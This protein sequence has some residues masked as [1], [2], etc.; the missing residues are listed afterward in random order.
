MEKV[1][2][3]KCQ[4][5]TFGFVSLSREP[6]IVA[7]ALYGIIFYEQLGASL[8][9]LG[10][11][12]A[13]ARGF[14]ILNDPIIAS[15]TDNTTTRIGKRYPWI[16]GGCLFFAGSIIAFWTPP[17]LAGIEAWFGVFYLLLW[18]FASI[19]HI[20][21]SAMVPEICRDVEERQSI[22]AH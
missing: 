19:V 13:L 9:I 2:L 12:I 21:Y 22:F 4:L 17:D 1:A 10:F 5:W 6:V 16:L 14:D 8:A 18:F 11:L 15:L 3:T 20:P 7:C